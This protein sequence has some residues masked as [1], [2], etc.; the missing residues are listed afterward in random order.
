MWCFISI[1]K[2]NVLNSY[3]CCKTV[4]FNLAKTSIS[5]EEIPVLLYTVDK[6]THNTKSCNTLPIN[7]VMSQIIGRHFLRLFGFILIKIKSF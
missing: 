1:N 6:L 4:L 5:V 3:Y 7:H 2:E